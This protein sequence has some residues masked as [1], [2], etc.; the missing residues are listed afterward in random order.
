MV[1]LIHFGTEIQSYFKKL[2]WSILLFQRLF[3]SSH[4]QDQFLL[5]FIPA[6]IKVDQNPNVEKSERCFFEPLFEPEVEQKAWLLSKKLFMD[7]IK[8]LYDVNDSFAKN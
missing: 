7:Q 8:V 4:E 3:W 2:L 5:D 6:N 1:I